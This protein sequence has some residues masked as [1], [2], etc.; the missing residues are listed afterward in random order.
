MIK[1]KKRD[2]SDNKKQKTSRKG[3]KKW[4]GKEGIIRDVERFVHNYETKPK[5]PLVLNA[6]PTSTYLAQELKHGSTSTHSYKKKKRQLPTNSSHPG[7]RR[8]A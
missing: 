7:G 5:L 1:E 6:S 2:Q 4:D 3:R 8:S